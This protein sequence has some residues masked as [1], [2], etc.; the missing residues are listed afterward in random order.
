MVVKIWAFL[1][2]HAFP[3]YFVSIR[4]F[5]SCGMGSERDEGG[6]RGQA[7]SIHKIQF[8]HTLPESWRRWIRFEKEMQG[9]ACKDDYRTTTKRKR[10]KDPN[11]IVVGKRC[12]NATIY[13]Y[14]EV[15][16]KNGIF[17]WTEETLDA[18]FSSLYFFWPL[19]SWTQIRHIMIIQCCVKDIMNE[20]N[21]KDKGEMATRNLKMVCW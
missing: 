19:A 14:K 5:K 18:F 1:I 21:K 6:P 2:T 12:N 8:H 20:Y 9:T 10:F 17:Y 16:K 11:K 4:Y 7:I 13:T 15:E 3:I